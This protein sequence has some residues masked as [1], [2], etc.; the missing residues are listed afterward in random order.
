MKCLEICTVD[1]RIMPLIRCKMKILCDRTASDVSFLNTTLLR[2]RNAAFSWWG[3]TSNV[4]EPQNL[5]CLY[6]EASHELMIV[7]LR[8]HMN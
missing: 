8:H 6:L 2:I 3:N 1:F 5:H 4:F 7:T